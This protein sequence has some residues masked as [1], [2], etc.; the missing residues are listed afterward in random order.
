MLQRLS[1]DHCRY[2]VIITLILA[3]KDVGEKES[4]GW[5][6]VEQMHD[7][8]SPMV[9]EKRLQEYFTYGR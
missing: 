8:V 6:L 4:L 1:K 2:N 9:F 3:L 5:L 7:N